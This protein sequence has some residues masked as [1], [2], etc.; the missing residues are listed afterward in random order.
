MA[1]LTV[2]AS[3]REWKMYSC[4]D[5]F[6]AFLNNLVILTIRTWA[7]YNRDRKMR[8]FLST[9][10]VVSFVANFTIAAF[11][12]KTLECKHPVG[13]SMFVF[14]QSSDEE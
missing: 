7:V 6:L 12:I 5:S 11:F 3:E 14:Y 4:M 10:F 8:I 1:L 2:L 13:Y 9:L